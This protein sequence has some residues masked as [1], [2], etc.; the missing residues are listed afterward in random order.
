MLKL[1]GLHLRISACGTIRGTAMTT[2]TPKR[3]ITRETPKQILSEDF[4]EI[5]WPVSG[6]WGYTQE[7][8]VIID[9]DN[10]SSAISVENRFIEYKTYEERGISNE[11]VCIIVGVDEYGKLFGVVAFK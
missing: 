10:S 9:A 8:A 11:Q 4:K 1:C 5:K 3:L 6:G 2:F 7:D